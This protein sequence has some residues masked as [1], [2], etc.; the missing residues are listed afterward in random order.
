M[1]TKMAMEKGDDRSAKRQEPGALQEFGGNAM[2][3]WTNFTRFLSDVRAEMRKVVAPSW[4][5]V[6]ITTSVV[7]VAVFIFGLFFFVVDYIFNIGIHEL[8]LKLGGLQ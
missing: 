8:L 6:K 4:K 1:A 7:I 3:T 2:G 5:D